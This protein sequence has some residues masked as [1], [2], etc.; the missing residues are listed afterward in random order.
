[1]QKSFNCSGLYFV[2]CEKCNKNSHWEQKQK[3]GELHSDIYDLVALKLTEMPKWKNGASA[4][5]NLHHQ[6]LH[7][8]KQNY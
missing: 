7:K 5:V 3:Q 2:S 1:M 8:H 6:K 4:S